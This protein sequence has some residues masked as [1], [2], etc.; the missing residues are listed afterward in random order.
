MKL[1]FL[2]PLY[3][4][5]GPYACAYLDTSR[6][7]DDP[8]RAVER[9]RSRLRADL[10]A[11]GADPATIGAVSRAVGGDLDPSGDQGRAVFA[12]HGR[13][14]LTAALPR[15][16]RRDSAR[17]TML[18]DVMPLALQRAPDIPYLA[19]AVRHTGAGGR[20]ME[21]TWQAGRWPATRVADGNSRRR[22]VPA[23]E[24]GRAA[25]T[26]ARHLTELSD[27][28][29]AEVIVLSGDRWARDTIAR[30][31]PP[32]LRGRTARIHRGNDWSP[33]DER[34]LLEDELDYLLGGRLAEAD[35]AVVRRFLTSRARRNGA[36]EGLAAT[37][38]ALRDGRVAAV[39]VNELFD[40]HLPL[41]VGVTPRQI[42]LTQR[43]LAAHGVVSGWSEET[44]AALVRAMVGGG[45]ELVVVPRVEL[46]LADGVGV[47]LRTPEGG[48]S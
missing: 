6:D 28:T 44:G 8:D 20:G 29:G 36:A 15:P 9:R 25:T 42:A 22:R 31:L 18:P 27:R 26:V 4:R 46:P 35:R 40:P 45:A 24:R 10:A 23:D 2:G 5:Q 14:A 32:R 16:P 1:G 17:F 19:A 33:R 30:E 12:A 39:L 43:E 7:L 13:L 48:P 38:A 3:A 41:H 21:V 34:T 11:Q 37:V 47:L